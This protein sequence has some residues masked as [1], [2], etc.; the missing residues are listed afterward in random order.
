MVSKQY[1]LIPVWLTYCIPC[2]LVFCCLL[3]LSIRADELKITPDTCAITPERPMCNLNLL[4]EYQSNIPKSLCIWIVKHTATLACF[5]DS[6]GFKYRVKLTLAEDTSFELRDMNN[7]DVVATSIVRV[8]K[9]EPANTRR[10]RGL[11]WNLL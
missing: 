3:S 11:N 4:I 1:S 10:R 5:K 6:F 9:F 7:N 8:A 2:I